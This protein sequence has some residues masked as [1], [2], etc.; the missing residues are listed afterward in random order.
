MDVFTRRN[1]WDCGAQAQDKC[2]R[3]GVGKVIGKPTEQRP[4]E[5]SE[6]NYI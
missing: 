6:K 3:A 4:Q 2:E 1:V 5:K